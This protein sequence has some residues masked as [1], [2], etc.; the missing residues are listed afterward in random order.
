MRE[1]IEGG[2]WVACFLSADDS[3]AAVEQALTPGSEKEDLVREIATHLAGG[4]PEE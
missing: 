1:N 2:G 3:G 4:E